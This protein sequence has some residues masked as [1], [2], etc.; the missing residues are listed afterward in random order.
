MSTVKK[1]QVFL[2]EFSRSLEV[3][4][5]TAWS[6]VLVDWVS[7]GAWVFTVEV[8]VGPAAGVEVGVNELARVVDQVPSE[9]VG[10]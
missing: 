3:E 10:T 6:W 7:V 2:F 5:L 4:I 9:T 1:E 8:V